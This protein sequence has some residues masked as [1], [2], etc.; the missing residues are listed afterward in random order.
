MAIISRAIKEILSCLDSDPEREGLLKTPERYAK[1]MM[2]LTSGY[3]LSIPDVVN[4]S[5]FNEHHDGLV[6]V[7]NIDVFSLCEHHLVPFMGK[8]R[9]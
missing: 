6:L 8:V 1:A 3:Q 2:F 5:I 4:E 9:L 7:K